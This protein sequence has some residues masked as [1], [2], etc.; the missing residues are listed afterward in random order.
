VA[1]RIDYVRAQRVGNALV[2]ERG[3]LVLTKSKGEMNRNIIRFSN[4]RQYQAESSIS[5][6]APAESAPAGVVPVRETVLPPGLLLAVVL[7]TG[8]DPASA[9]VGDEIRAHV[10]DELRDRGELILP[11]D[12]TI[13]GR[14]RRLERRGGAKPFILVAIELTRAEWDHAAATFRGALEETKVFRGQVRNIDA[15][16]DPGTGVIGLQDGKNA[17]VPEGLHMVW[18]TL[19]SK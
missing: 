12:A 4:C 17:R 1:S 2:P 6:E 11:K 16:R 14:I 7:D 5:F 18:R 9:S 10:G 15:P 3:E 13:R 19:Y 8:I